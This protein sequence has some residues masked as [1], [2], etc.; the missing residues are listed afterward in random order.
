MPRTNVPGLG[1]WLI[2]EPCA[3]FY[4]ESYNK[5]FQTEFNYSQENKKIRMSWDHL[6]IMSTVHK[7]KEQSYYE[8]TRSLIDLVNAGIISTQTAQERETKYLNKTRS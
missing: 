1:E 3:N 6:P 5:I 2:A 8:Y 7:A 4:W